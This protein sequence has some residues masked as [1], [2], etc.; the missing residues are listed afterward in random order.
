ME[1]CVNTGNNGMSVRKENHSTQDNEGN[2]SLSMDAVLII[3]LGEARYN[4]KLIL[5]LGCYIFCL[6]YLELIFISLS[7][8]ILSNYETGNSEFVGGCPRHSR[9][10]GVQ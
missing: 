5:T 2:P 10:Y 4:F 7:L 6:F 8:C 1:P 9:L 3:F